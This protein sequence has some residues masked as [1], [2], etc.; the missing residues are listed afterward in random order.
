MTAQSMGLHST[1]RLKMQTSL[2]KKMMELHY[3]TASV[4]NNS[5]AGQVSHQVVRSSSMR[6]AMRAAAR[7]NAQPPE[8][9]I[10]VFRHMNGHDPKL[11]AKRLVADRFWKYVERYQ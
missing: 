7:F 5:M 6:Q 3:Y 11:V 10:S 9:V 8:A 1:G 4:D 2:F